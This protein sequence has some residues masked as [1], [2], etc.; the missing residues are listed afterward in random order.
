MKVYDELAFCDWEELGEA[1]ESRLWTP[2]ENAF[3]TII[4]IDNPPVTLSTKTG[5]WWPV[6]EHVEVAFFLVSGRLD[7]RLVG[8]HLTGP[9]TQ[10]EAARLVAVDDAMDGWLLHTLAKHGTDPEFPKRVRDLAAS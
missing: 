9:L 10:G 8:G 6:G 3:R 4:R 5:L 7:A 2:L 1:F